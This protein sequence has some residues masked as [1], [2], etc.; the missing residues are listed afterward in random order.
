MSIKGKK[1]F[2]IDNNMAYLEIHPDI[3]V[4]GTAAAPVVSGR[5][6]IDPGII[7]YQSS[8]FTMTR[9]LIDFVNP[10]AIDP[11]LDIQS[12][13][14]VRD[15]NVQLGISG[16]SSALDF[17]LSSEPRLDHGDIISLLLRGNH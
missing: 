17:T 12:E 2:I 11:E 13:R 16:T 3:S 10:Y 6:E 5:S 7:H 8:D 14:T 9:G 4:Q 15:W 1:P